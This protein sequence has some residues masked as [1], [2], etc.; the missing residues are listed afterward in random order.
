MDHFAIWLVREILPNCVEV[1]IVSMFMSKE[2]QHSLLYQITYFLVAFRKLGSF[3]DIFRTV[4]N[5][6]CPLSAGSDFGPFDRPV[7]DPNISFETCTAACAS[8][9]FPM[10]GIVLGQECCKDHLGS[11]STYI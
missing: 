8:D 6:A 4:D 11:P 5:A 10:A 7:S 9:G 3:I 2:H 1:P